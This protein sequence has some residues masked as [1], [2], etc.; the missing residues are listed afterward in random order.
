MYSKYIWYTCHGIPPKI[1]KSIASIQDVVSLNP[2]MVPIQSA[3][4]RERSSVLFCKSAAG[5]QTHCKNFLLA[6]Y[7]IN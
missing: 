1:N 2:P 7:F 4:F 5:T 3:A 6:F